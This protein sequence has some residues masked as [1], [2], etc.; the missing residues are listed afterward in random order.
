MQLQAV[1]DKNAYAP[2]EIAVVNYSVVSQAAAEVEHIDVKL[3][4]SMH[5]SARGHGHATS[6]VM[7]EVVL[8]GMS[9]AAEG[10]AQQ[11]SSSTQIA[12]PVA[13]CH[14][15]LTAGRLV[16]RHAIQLKSKTGGCCVKDP[17]LNL[18]ITLYR[19]G[20][21]Q[22]VVGVVVP[23]KAGSVPMAQVVAYSPTAATTQQAA[24]L[25]PV[26]MAVVV[27][28]AAQPLQPQA[29]M[30]MPV[31]QQAGSTE[32][33][34]VQPAALVLAAVAN[35]A[36]SPAPVPGTKQSFCTNCG[37]ARAQQPGSKFCTG[38]GAQY[39]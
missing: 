37:E 17:E 30:A 2:G 26:L 25:A 20:P 29:M 36:L 3:V 18:P 16:V 38:C 6:R 35:P 32:P 34:I 8:P 12:V 4:E 19:Q 1:T 11:T 7:A 28:G 31:A 5:W 33:I 14:F 21:A 22:F 27:D 24:S 10:V 23:E 39:A 9:S 15:S 13:E